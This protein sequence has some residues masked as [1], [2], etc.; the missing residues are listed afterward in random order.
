MSII[1]TILEITLIMI[2]YWIKVKATSGNEDRAV[3]LILNFSELKEVAGDLSV[4]FNLPSSVKLSLNFY[5]DMVS[6][7]S[8]R[9]S[10]QEK[11]INVLHIANRALLLKK[12]IIKI[13]VVKKSTRAELCRGWSEQFLLSLG[14]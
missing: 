9:C 6:P 1:F 8:P 5:L 13:Q 12:N 10:V 11:I 14:S 2:N 3:R 7:F 4:S